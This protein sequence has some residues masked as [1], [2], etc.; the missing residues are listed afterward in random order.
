MNHSR[1]GNDTADQFLGWAS[2]GDGGEKR[3]DEL[4]MVKSESRE[5][6]RKS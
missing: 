4:G 3:G 1:K 5:G 2:E 6:I